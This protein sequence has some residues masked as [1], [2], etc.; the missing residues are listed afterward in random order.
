MP[1]GSLISQTTPSFRGGVSQQPDVLRF[2]DQV[3]EQI[4]AFP[5][6]VEGLQKRPPTMHIKRLGDTVDYSAVK[7]HVINRDEN[8][9]YILELSNG[10]LR[11]WDLQGN[12]KVVKFPNGKSYLSSSDVQNDF[13]AITIADYTL[14]LNKKVVTRM[15]S[16]RTPIVNENKVIYDL[17]NVQ[18]GKGYA[19]YINGVFEAG[20]RPP[21]GSEAWQSKVTQT[22]RV[23]DMLY[24]SLR[25]VYDVSFD[26]GSFIKTT[27]Y[28]GMFVGGSD[29]DTKFI[30]AVPKEGTGIL[31]DYTVERIGDSVITIQ[32]KD[33]KQF[34]TTVK[35]GYA[36]QNFKSCAGAVRSIDKL[37]NDAP[38]GYVVKISGENESTDDDYYVRWDSID[39][40]WK[41]C[42]AEDIQYKIDATTMP[43]ALV[44]ESD[45]T[46]TFKMLEWADRKTG[47]DNSNPIPSFI[48]Y[49]INDIFFY[50]NRLGFVSDENIILS[51]SGD[52]F[53]FW[54]ESAATIADT[55][56][57]DISISSNRVSILT[58]AIPFARELM[59]FS[60]EGQ[61]VLSSDG[62]MTPKTV[63]VDQ[64]TTFDYSKSAQ[65]IGIGQSIFFINDR[66]NYSSLM[67]YYTVQDVAEM[68]NADDVSA[69]VPTYIPRGVYRLSGN[70]IENTV[71]M[72]SKTKPNTVWV[73]KFMTTNGQLTQ[74][75]WGKWEFRYDGSQVCLA[76]FV[77]ATMYFLINTEGGL[78]LEK[79]IL[80]GNTTDFEDE[81][82]RLFMDRKVGY[83]IP[84]GNKYS[85]YN[86]YTEVSFRD[87]YGAI[88][89]RSVAKYCAVDLEG[90]Y[91][92]ITE[93]TDEGVF[94]LDGD[95]RG[96]K[97]YF[98]RLY[99]FHVELSKQMIKQSNSN[100]TVISEDEGRLQLRYYWFNYSDT[101][102]FKVTVSNPYKNRKFEYV[103]TSKILGTK[104]TILGSYDIH[105]GKFKFPIQE[106]NEEVS[107]VVT[108]NEPLPLNIISGG[109]EG[110]Y[111]RKTAK[112]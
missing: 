31:P 89:K 71:T 40:L 43:W 84:S 44:R 13:R 49:T 21:D 62:V 98:G 34:S 38:D 95:L 80:T 108:S 47:D 94:R 61:F 85:D 46:F 56:T 87:I 50:R 35:D 64:I 2:A 82:V 76:E 33:K 5:S 26:P 54:F 53:N 100:G 92:E 90:K 88:P 74:S 41:E 72:L 48:D 107:I 45:G 111:V 102:V 106:S 73:Y 24:N 101:G 110:L 15:T 17:R 109:W 9:Q 105:T 79:A 27:S 11:V 51:A 67:R 4:N 59:L 81:P 8:E 19:I 57:I 7:Y 52:F 14:I 10:N 16:D 6:E 30:V 28:E 58:D 12:E 65:P 23:A 42:P 66:V 83:T 93:W 20:A 63:K 103:S 75:A 22:S 86:D 37:P 96:K 32:R 29:F 78:F 69:H 112:V 91:H 104:D 60:R 97:L 99:T 1:R 36:G 39:K 68:K 18:Y 25:G 77:N 70:T 3:E 55:D